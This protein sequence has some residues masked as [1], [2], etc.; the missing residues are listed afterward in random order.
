MKQG[1]ISWK[2]VFILLGA[3]VGIC[4][5]ASVALFIFGRPVADALRAR[6]WKTDPKLA[7][8]VA[9]QMIDYDLPPAYQ[10]L[11]FLDMGSSADTVMIANL[12]QPADFILI[13]QVPD[14]ILATEYQTGVEE[15]WSREISEH[16]YDTHTVSTQAVTVRGLPTTLR[17]MEGTDENGR[18]IRQGVC[19]F[20]G[21]S[22]DVLLVLV[23]GQDTWDQTMVEQFLQSIR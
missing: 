13:T 1:K 19:M 5:I 9:H 8:Q 18:P 10:E 17:I 14:G 21:K 4:L 15:K 2:R 3:L 6:L 20:T 12:E 11:K 22:G 16:H 23:A 7:A